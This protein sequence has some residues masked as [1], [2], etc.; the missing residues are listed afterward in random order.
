LYYICNEF[1]IVIHQSVSK[2]WQS[3]CV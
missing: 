3:I 1:D 2:P